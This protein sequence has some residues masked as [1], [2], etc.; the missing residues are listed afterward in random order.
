L[1]LRVNFHFIFFK[2]RELMFRFFLL[3]LPLLALY[4]G[5]RD[6]YSLAVTQGEPATLVEGCVSVTLPAILISQNTMP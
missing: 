4:G 5:N 1:Q 3:F 6:P 2:M